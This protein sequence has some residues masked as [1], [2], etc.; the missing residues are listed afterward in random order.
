MATAQFLAAGLILMQGI[1]ARRPMANV[2]TIWRHFDL[3]HLLS[4]MLLVAIGVVMVYSSFDAAMPED[5]PF[6]MRFA[7]R[8]AVFAVLG[9]G[10]YLFAAAIDYRVLGS[11]SI[12]F[13]GLML[14][15][16]AITLTLGRT[17]FGATSRL[18]ASEYFD[19]QT[20]ELAKV[21]M[22]LL[23]A[24]Y[25]GRDREALESPMPFLLSMLL[26]VPPLVL[27]YI[28]PDFGQTLMLLATWFGMAFLG[29]VRWRHMLLLAVLGLL[30]A[31]VVWFRAEPYMRGRIIMFLFPGEDPSGASYN[32]NQALISIG[33]G[34]WLG[35]GLLRGT[36]SQL[37]FLRVRHTDFIFS[38]L[39]EEMGFLGSLLLLSLYAI[40]ITRLVRIAT[41]TSDRYGRL[42]VVG[43][44]CM[45]FVQTVV[46]VG[47]NV[48][49]LPVTGLP[50]PLVSYGGS[51]IVTMMLALGLTQ[52][53][54]M[55]SKPIENDLLS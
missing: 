3:L 45:L 18:D 26:L 17:D 22:I 2:R 50:L 27:I 48:N 14:V 29:G 43:V 7:M 52:S 28:Q 40:L 16:L 55:R 5:T 54:A 11:L 15:L 49:I 25:L 8:Q 51:S 20:S 24:R 19:I 6:L 44:T 30:V 13:Y 42:V 23:F 35:K 36:Q 37:H 21:V 9:L 38:V 1:A 47:F 53:V 10:V 34:G 12:W 46:N 33:S 39:A 4:M 31:P 41:T 32:V